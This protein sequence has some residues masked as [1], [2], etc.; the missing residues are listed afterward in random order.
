MSQKRDLICQSGLI[1]KFRQWCIPGIR[2][3][4]GCCICNTRIWIPVLESCTNLKLTS[5]GPFPLLVSTNVLYN[6]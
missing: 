3:L 4:A 2:E 1:P 5:R 6:T